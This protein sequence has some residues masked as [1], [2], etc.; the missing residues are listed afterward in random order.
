MK[1]DPFGGA[2][3]R[4]D[5]DELVRSVGLSMRFATRSD[6]MSSSSS[7]CTAASR[8]RAA[9]AIAREIER[10]DPAW[11]EEPVP[12]ENAASLARV[13]AKVSAPVATGERIHTR[14]EFR[15]L[16][17]LGC[18][19]VIQPD[20]TM[21]GGIRETLQARVLGRGLQRRRRAT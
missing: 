7:R 19:D 11:I 2:T 4:L 9:V 6:P 15:E 5:R 20:M 3:T 14:H 18:V 10:F 8:P 12:P 21:F 13:T 16:L 1:F 17:E